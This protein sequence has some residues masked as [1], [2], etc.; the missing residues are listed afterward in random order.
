MN[1]INV[2]SV[3][4][5]DAKTTGIT[6][7]CIHPFRLHNENRFISIAPRRRIRTAAIPSVLFFNYCLTCIFNIRN[8]FLTVQNHC[9]R[10]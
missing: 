4:R 2:Q 9:P 7:I 6:F 8:L 1:A 5:S 3:S 10:E